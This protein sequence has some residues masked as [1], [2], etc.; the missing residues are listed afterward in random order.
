LAHPLRIRILA[1]LSERAASPAQ[2]AERLDASLPTVSYHVQTLKKLRLISLVSTRPVRGAVEHFYEATEPP[3]FSDEAWSRL[4]AS[5]KQRMLSAMLGQIG[6]YVNAAAA[7][8]GF[9]RADAHF[10][11]TGL[12]LDERGFAELAAATAR[13]LSEADEIQ[14]AARRRLAQEGEEGTVQ[15]GLVLLAFEAVPFSDQRRTGSA[16]ER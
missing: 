6:D 4:D 10:S 1:M 11:R 8:G 9:D 5:G 12:K 13:W 3:R 2:L 16:L 15:A 14:A 7:A